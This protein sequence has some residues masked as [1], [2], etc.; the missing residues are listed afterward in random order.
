MPNAAGDP[1]LDARGFEAAAFKMKDLGLPKLTRAQVKT[2]LESSCVPPARRALGRQ[3][4]PEHSRYT[5]AHFVELALQP[6]GKFFEDFVKDPKF[7]GEPAHLERSLELV[8]AEFASTSVDAGED[9][10]INEWFEYLA[11][12]LEKSTKVRVPPDFLSDAFGSVVPFHMPPTRAIAHIALASQACAE[13]LVGKTLGLQARRGALAVLADELVEA[14]AEE[15]VNLGVRADLVGGLERSWRAAR[16]TLAPSDDEGEVVDAPPTKRSRTK[17]SIV[18]MDKEKTQQ[19]KFALANRQALTRLPSTLADA[20]QLLGSACEETLE[21]L[22]EFLEDVVVGRHA[23]VRHMVILDIAVD[24]WL[25]H[26]IAERRG[27]PCT[28]R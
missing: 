17:A 3:T 22:T 28:L 14:L 27:N 26:Q 21:R 24:Y 2:F 23:L 6:A 4:G 5:F 18:Q 9:L 16:G 25:A 12:L 19:V 7:A 10:T 1:S 8:T 20:A 11:A 13:V 15:E